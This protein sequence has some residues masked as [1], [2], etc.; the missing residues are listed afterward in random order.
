[1]IVYLLEIDF[2]L[3]RSNIPNAIQLN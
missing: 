3:T 2:G 1:M